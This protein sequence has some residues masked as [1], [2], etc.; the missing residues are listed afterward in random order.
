MP[1]GQWYVSLLIHHRKDLVF[2]GAKNMFLG[3]IKCE[4]VYFLQ[5]M[6]PGSVPIVILTEFSF[7]ESLGLASILLTLIG[8]DYFGGCGILV[9]GGVMLDGHTPLHI[10]DVGSVTAQ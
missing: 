3:Q 1:D 5:M 4:A 8:S 6:S 10:F 9:L 7:G 2:Y